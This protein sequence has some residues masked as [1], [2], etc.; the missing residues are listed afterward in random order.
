MTPREFREKYTDYKPL[1]DKI[2]ESITIRTYVNGNSHDDTRPST[3]TEKDII[4][5]IVYSALLAYGWSDLASIDSILDMAEFTLH[6][7]LP[8]ANTYDTIYIP[9]RKLIGTW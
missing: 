7:F 5:K 1:A 6:Q 4:S 8:D 9:M 3:D 2:A